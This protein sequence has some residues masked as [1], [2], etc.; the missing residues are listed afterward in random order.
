M[1]FCAKNC[2]PL[3]KTAENQGSNHNVEHIISYERWSI[4]FCPEMTKRVPYASLTRNLPPP[5]ANHTNQQ[6]Q[7]FTCS[8]TSNLL[9]RNLYFWNR[10][11]QKIMKQCK[12]VEAERPSSGKNGLDLPQTLRG[13]SACLPRKS[14]KTWELFRVLFSCVVFVLLILLTRTLRVPSANLP[15]TTQKKHV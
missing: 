5:S 10:H 9:Y 1:T 14:W 3:P 12:W 4:F 13:P 11:E 8:N 6:K 15:R 7:K 2:L